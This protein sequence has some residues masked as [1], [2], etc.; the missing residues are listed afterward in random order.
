MSLQGWIGCYF[1][2]D[3][4]NSGDSLYCHTQNLSP[5]LESR[6][7]IVGTRSLACFSRP[8][9]PIHRIHS[10]DA[11][12]PLELLK[13]PRIPSVPSKNDVGAS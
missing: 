11:A 4:G 9:V 10:G 7:G 12:A 13:I 2:G 3:G 5:V 8:Q 1:R 6:M